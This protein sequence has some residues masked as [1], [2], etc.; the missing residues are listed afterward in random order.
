LLRFRSPS[1]MRNGTIDYLDNTFNYSL[2]TGPTSRG[3]SG[4][5]AADLRMLLGA[6]EHVYLGGELQMGGVTRSPTQ[7]VADS[8]GGIDFDIA[9]QTM[10]G[11]AGVAGVRARAGIVELDGEVAAG[12]HVYTISIDTLDGGD[13]VGQAASETIV[14]PML[15]TRLRGVLWVAP[16]WFLSAQVGTTP[17]DRGDVSVA[18]LL[19]SASRPY[20]DPFSAQPP[21]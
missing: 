4:A 17:L 7:L 20:G 12:M 3:D 1:F 16:R 19:G 15:E 5:V 2:G 9:A 10:V 21:Y 18:F 14:T 6:S 13:D 11:L 8:G